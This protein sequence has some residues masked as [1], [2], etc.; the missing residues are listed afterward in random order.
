MTK[1][2]AYTSASG[3]EM[4]S[5]E[6]VARERKL[7][8]NGEPTGKTY[9]SLHRAGQ[10]KEVVHVL[11]GAGYFAYK[12][13][14][15]G[16][17]GGDAQGESL[18][19]VLFKEALA[20]VSHT[21]LELYVPTPQGP[22][23]WKK[24]VPV[25][26][27]AAR[28]EAP[29]HRQAGAPFVADVYVEFETAD[30]LGLKWDGRMCVEIKHSHAV[31]AQKQDELRAL[32]MPVIEVDVSGPPY[33]YPID[34]DATTDELESR[35]R[36]RLKRM[37]ESDNGFLK[38]VVLSNPSSNAY[39]KKLVDGQRNA[40]AEQRRA[41]EQLQAQLAGRETELQQA[42]DAKAKSD[43]RLLDANAALSE[44]KARLKE[45]S[46]AQ[47][48]TAAKNHALE[49]ELA[50]ARRERLAARAICACLILLLAGIGY[51]QLAPSS[52]A[53]PEPPSRVPGSVAHEPR[54]G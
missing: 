10:R 1:K 19:H 11:K 50:R 36:A 7:R 49:Q 43:E 51:W 52:S 29:V 13:T 27:K 24:L 26:I 17:P 18:N 30:S 45:I 9:Y 42:A 23:R 5:A 28:T 41:L 25:R 35:H 12:G 4:V 21:R 34:D 15:G 14:G 54:G 8:Y 3:K 40:L 38:A 32:G 46:D 20:T 2:R 39:L 22:V 16:A 53:Q 48:Q 47:M 33:A 44:M 37:F 31:D 6:A